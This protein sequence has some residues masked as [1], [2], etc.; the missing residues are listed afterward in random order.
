MRLIRARLTALLTAL[1]T[2][3][4]LAAGT[5][6]GI[7]CAQPARTTDLAGVPWSHVGPAGC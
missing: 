2:V 5:L 7:A 3:L 6:T 4:L 1:L